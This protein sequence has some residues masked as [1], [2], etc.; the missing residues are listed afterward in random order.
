MKNKDTIYVNGRGWF[1][2]GIDE[3]TQT[4]RWILIP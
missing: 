2:Y 4:Q 3:E 1:R